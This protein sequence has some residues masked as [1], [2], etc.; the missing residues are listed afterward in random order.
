ML[1]WGCDSKS[2]GFFDL[3]GSA[4]KS[5]TFTTDF[6]YGLAFNPFDP[7]VFASYSKDGTQIHIWDVRNLKEGNVKKETEKY[8]FFYSKR[9]LFIYRTAFSPSIPSTQRSP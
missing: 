8:I 5:Q 2:I 6:T 1:F 3:R 7:D 4:G 9:T